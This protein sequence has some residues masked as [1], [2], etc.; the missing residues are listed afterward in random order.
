[1]NP[2]LINETKEMALETPE[3]L[4]L[5]FV[6]KALQQSENDSSIQVSSIF[7]ES[8]TTKGD[9]YVSDVIR[10]TVEFS[11]DQG[12][13]RITEKK[14]IIAK[15]SPTDGGSRQKLV[16]DVG[17]FNFEISMMSN[18]LNKMNELLGPKH[19]VSGKSLYIHKGNPTVL[20]MED[21]TPLGFHKADRSSSLDLAHCTLALQGLARFHAATV[22]L[23]EKEP[24]QKEMYTKGVFHEEHPLEMKSYF[25]TG[26]KALA[27]ECANWSGFKKYAEKIAKFSDRIYEIGIDA[28][29]FS[30]DDF[31][32][33]THG[34][35]SVNNM[36][37]KY[38]NDG[39]PI[40]HICIDF[41]LCSYTSPAIDLLYFFNTSAPD[42]IE[43]KQNILLNEYLETLSATMNQLGCKTRPPTME[44]LKAVL[45]RRASYGMIT[46]FTVLPL[47]RLRMTE[48]KDLDEIL[49]TGA[50]NNSNLKSEFFKTLMMKQI[51]VY[52]EWGLLDL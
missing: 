20:V 18:T 37:F 23:C 51:P 29:K 45:K 10:I 39:K 40:E 34:D 35:F 31:N 27:N 12:D 25:I 32:V 43:S 44:E 4:N 19:R 2:S 33:I 13:H 8:A 6:N 16:E 48:S 26:T 1:M 52:D 7:S 47:L 3:W 30:E 5:G 49:N 50:Y 11:R 21:L 41:Q 38:D 46:S 17:Y 22:A 42:V 24:K 36:L 9:N 15:V 14:S 28:S